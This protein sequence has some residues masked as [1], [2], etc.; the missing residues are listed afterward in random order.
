M[1]RAYHN[2]T[3]IAMQAAW[4]SLY[5][6]S[7]GDHGTLAFFRSR[8]NRVAVTKEPKKDVNATVDFLEAVIKG[9][10][11]ACACDIL[12]IT[13]LDSTI[14]LPG[15]FS[16]STPAEKFIFIKDIA[17]KVVDRLTL[18]ESSF[19][20]GEG[21]DTDEG[22]GAYNYARVLCHF[23]SLVMEFR[24]AW[25]EGDGERIF[26][27]WRL[28]LP[29]FHVAGC[30]KYCLE[31]LRIQLQV[32]VVLSPNLAHQVKWNRFVNV[33]G[34]AGRN[35]HEHINKLIKFIIHNMGP[36]LTE[37]SAA[38]CVSPLNAICKK[39]DAESNNVPVITS[40]HS[41]KS[42]ITDIKKV[43]AVVL[44]RKLLSPVTAIAHP[45]RKHSAFPNFHLNPLNNWDRKKMISWIEGKKRDYRKYKGR[46]CQVTMDQSDSEDIW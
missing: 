5:K 28:F 17:Q 37:G 12:N 8:L 45:A 2:N 21:D 15:D 39:F 23:G 7:S 27:C 42:D 29:H 33:K 35:I 41:T 26:R 6:K 40:A 31:A 25:A 22:D 3:Y 20:P 1:E 16:K 13:S 30:T 11:L 46:V 10:W 14:P 44:E 34:G 36:N 4:K 43:V 32:S 24:D 38:R 9:H 19:L 18:V